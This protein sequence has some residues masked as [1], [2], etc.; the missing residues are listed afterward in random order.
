MH[1]A[2]DYKICGQVMEGEVL[3]ILQFFNGMGRKS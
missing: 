3:G 1:E 2:S